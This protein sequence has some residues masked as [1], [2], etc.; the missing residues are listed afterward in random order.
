MNLWPFSNNHSFTNMF[1]LVDWKRHQ[2]CTVSTLST[3]R[4]ATVQTFSVPKRVWCLKWLLFNVAAQYTCEASSELRK[5]EK[6]RN[7]NPQRILWA[8]C[9]EENIWFQMYTAKGRLLITK[10]I[11]KFHVIDLQNVAN[12]VLF[13]AHSGSTLRFCPRYTVVDFEDEDSNEWNLTQK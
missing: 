3:G 11:W 1:S 13:P 12:F 8:V 10:L 5:C 9:R 7:K 4:K 6:P 2:V